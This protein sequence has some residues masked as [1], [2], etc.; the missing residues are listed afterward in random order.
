MVINN[1]VRSKISRYCLNAVYQSRRFQL[2]EFALLRS[3]PY[4]IRSSGLIPEMTEDE[5]TLSVEMTTQQSD[6]Y[7]GLITRNFQVKEII[8]FARFTVYR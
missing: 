1:T 4:K 5:F 8:T 3:Q 7:I 6:K 2:D